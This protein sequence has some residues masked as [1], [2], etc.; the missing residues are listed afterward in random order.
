VSL[1]IVHPSVDPKSITK[2]ITGLRPRIETLA[3]NERRRKDGTPIEPP[4]KAALSVWLADLHDEKRL[5]SGD[6]P[7]S[8]FIVAEVGKLERCKRLIADIRQEGI[9]ALCIAMF[10][11]SNYSAAV[12]SAEAMKASGDLG[13]DLEL[14]CYYQGKNL[15]GV[16]P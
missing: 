15:A 5:Y 4:R 2:V 16:T 9:V 6:K 7:L 11:P 13:I 10:S 14:N 1:S 12:I 8:D 3:G